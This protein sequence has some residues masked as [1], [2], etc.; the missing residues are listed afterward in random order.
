M[1]PQQFLTHLKQAEP[2][3]AYLFLGPE[4]FQRDFCR[5]TLVER[6]LADPGER[7]DGVARHDLSEISL[8][9]VIEDACSPSLFS[10]RRVLLVSNAEAALPKGKSAGEEGAKGAALERY[11]RDP[12]PGVVLLFD[13]A[14]YGFQG[15]DKKKLERVRSFYS[16]VPVQVEFAQMT[17]QRARE[18]AVKRARLAGI[19]LGAEELDLLVDALGAEAARIAM[20]IDKL[21]LYSAGGKR[22]GAAEISKL[23]PE[24]RDSTIFALVDALGRSDRAASLDVLETL[25][26]QS[27]YLPLALSFLGTQFRLALAAKEAGLR[28]PQQIQGHFARQG[29]PMWPARAQQVSET[30]SKFSKAKLAAAL[31]AIY[32]ADKSLRDIRPDDRV[33]MEELILRLTG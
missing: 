8:A 4:P 12:S 5:R 31:E 33:V 25:I 14:R 21:R 3:A 18:F 29:T 23:V 1:T 13:A 7:E 16:A 28:T 32:G 6:V 19:E 10:S 30:V 15:E 24:A 20:E 27:E 17:R 11:L 22:I 9:A 26:R 2:A